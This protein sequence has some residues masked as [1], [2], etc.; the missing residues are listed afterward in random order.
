MAA[1]CLALAFRGIAQEAAPPPP[2]PA[3]EVNVDSNDDHPEIIIRQKGDK[4][5]KLTLEIRNGQVFLNGKPLEKFE[6]PNLEIEMR[7]PDEGDIALSI[8]PFRRNYWDDQQ[9]YFR[10][11]QHLN[12]DM[13]RRME[14]MNWKLRE[15]KSNA[16]FLGVS[17]RKA[18]AGG[19]LV[20]EV[21]KSSPA[22]KAGLKK[23][24]VITRL[25]D[26]KIES[27]EDLYETVH[28]L[29]PG[30]KVT[31][32]FKR[33]GKEQ[34]A[35]AVLGESKNAPFVYKYKYD[36]QMPE[37][38]AFPGPESFVWGPMPPK[39]GIKAQD[40]EDGKG[41]NVLDITQGS[42]AEKAGLKKGDVI[43]SYDGNEVNSANELVQQVREAR[44]KSTVK[45]KIL[46]SG[47]SQELEIRIPRKLR[48]AEL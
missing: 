41:V 47:K 35:P 26:E 43:T 1:I 14:D 40:A 13:Q 23:G 12:R 8:S 45:V 24:D 27:P 38:P 48:T 28:G 10:D 42:A 2:P 32:T 9:Q 31:V 46:R 34:T 37:M 30:D 20:L 44:D 25:N 19:A 22:E 5:S 16:A 36:Y 11:Q 3:P 39:L 7:K 4:D 15:L 21:T 17:S 18:D 33:D 6:D 29:K